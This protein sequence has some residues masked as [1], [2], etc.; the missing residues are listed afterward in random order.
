MPAAGQLDHWAD[1]LRPA[2]MTD[3]WVLAGCQ[4]ALSA[5]KARGAREMLE[6]LLEQL[7]TDAH[8]PAQQLQQL[9]DATPHAVSSCA[10]SHAFHACTC[11]GGVAHSLVV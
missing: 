9:R 1:V 6:A 5:W 8:G 10:N 11:L 4:R 3:L 7:A 2:R